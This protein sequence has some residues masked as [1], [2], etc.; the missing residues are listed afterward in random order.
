VSAVVLKFVGGA[1]AGTFGSADCFGFS[2]ILLVEASGHDRFSVGTLVV[3]LR[4]ASLRSVT[5]AADFVLFG[6][7][8][9]AGVQAALFVAV[10]L[11]ATND[12]GLCDLCDNE[13]RSP[14]GPLT[15][16]AID[17]TAVSVA[18]YL[19]LQVNGNT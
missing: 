6:L 8:L 5:A 16:L 15:H 7:A 14:R 2:E 1:K 10:L 17:R 13:R 4:P 18:F 12:F 19:L 9:H 11:F 3:V